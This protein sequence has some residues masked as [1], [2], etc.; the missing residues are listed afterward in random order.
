MTIIKVTCAVILRQKKVLIVQRSED[1]S[2]PLKWEFPGGKIEQDET[3]SECIIREIKVE[4]DVKINVQKRLT[5]L[6][7]FYN[8]MEIELIPFIVK[9]RS[10]KIRLTVHNDLK[11]VGK[12]EISKFEIADADKPIIKEL[13]NLS[14]I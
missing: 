8:K 14:M 2:L 4:L 7:H 13:V 11:W 10:G 5:P 6:T 1:M 9:V 3:E 12:N